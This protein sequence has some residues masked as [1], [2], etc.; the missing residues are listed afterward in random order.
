MSM[1]LGM[2]NACMVNGGIVVHKIPVSL[3]SWSELTA[4]Y[5]DDNRFGM[6]DESC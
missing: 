6:V 1:S 5:C 3:F 4:L 2:R